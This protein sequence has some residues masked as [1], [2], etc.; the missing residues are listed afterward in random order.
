MTQKDWKNFTELISRTQ[1]LYQRPPLDID[2][3]R[4]YFDLLS[5]LPFAAVA[6]GVRRH[7]MA[8]TGESGRFA[9]KPADIRLAL[10]GTPE[11]K[12]CSAW[13]KVLKAIKKLR[14]D[15]SVRFADDPAFHY[16]IEACGGWTQLCRMTP[17][18]S[19]PLFRRYYANAVRENIGWNSV[20]DH[21]AGQDEIRGSYLDPWTPEK[22]A[23]INTWEFTPEND[24]KRLTA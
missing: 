7:M 15:T 10:F 5:D 13:P 22:I 17:E 21:L 24:K 12:A 2:D 14:S 19:E 9:P 18:E 8:C 3:M 16:A 20:P 1:R 6:E 23:D 11:Q 4:L